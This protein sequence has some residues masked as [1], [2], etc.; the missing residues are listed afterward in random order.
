[1]PRPI[2]AAISPGGGAPPVIEDLLLADPLPDEVVLRIEAAGICHTDLGVGAWSEEPRVLGHEGAGTVVETGSAVTRLR[3]GDRVLATF[4]FCGTCPNCAGG[5]PAYCF[6]GIALN[7]E[8]ARAEPPLTRMDG[9]A[10][11]GAFFQQSCFATHALATER[12]CVKLPGWLDAYVAAPFGCGI[13][14][15]AGAVFNQLG[16]L[17]HRPLLV[18]GAGAV[19]CAAIMAGRIMGCDPLIV[20]EPVAARRELAISLGASHAFAGSE[21]DWAAQVVELTAGGVTAALD[22]AG[23]QATFEAALA[24]LHSGG[25]L[26]VLTL[27]GDFAQPVPHPG[28]ID[29]LT[30]RIVGVIEGDS[31]PETFLPRLFAYHGGGDLPVDRLIRTYP[32]ADIASAFADAASGAVIKPVLTFEEEHS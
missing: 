32:F 30:K 29:F 23:R 12:N 5:R 11:K 27:P 16:A 6:D 15:G 17:T 28:G 25:T 24:A 9:S 13:Q 7:L 19:G 14:T 31:V 22:T 21:A 8:G 2:R 3:K 18:I 20:V 26:G 4:G 1:M 10:V